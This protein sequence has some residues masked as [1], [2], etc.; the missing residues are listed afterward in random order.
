MVTGSRI[1]KVL[2]LALALTWAARGLGESLP[3]QLPLWEGNDIHDYADLAACDNGAGETKYLPPGISPTSRDSHE[4]PREWNGQ[5]IAWDE[6]AGYWVF[7]PPPG[8]PSRSGRCS[9]PAYPSRKACEANGFTWFPGFPE[10]ETTVNLAADVYGRDIKCDRT[11]MVNPN[12][13]PGQRVWQ[14]EV[15]GILWTAI[16]RRRAATR[17]RG[18]VA[19]MT[20]TTSG[21]PQWND[22]HESV[23]YNIDVGG[24]N[25]STRAATWLDTNQSGGSGPGKDPVTG[26]R[27][28]RYAVS[29]VA[30]PNYRVP[31]NVGTMPRAGGLRPW[32]RNEGVHA[33][34]WWDTVPLMN[35][36]ACTNCHGSV[37][38]GTEA[39]ARSGVRLGTFDDHTYWHAGNDKLGFPTTR[40]FDGARHKDTGDDTTSCT[41]CHASFMQSRAPGMRSLLD[42]M[43]GVFENDDWASDWRKQTTEPDARLKDPRRSHAMP[44]GADRT[45][46]GKAS[47]TKGNTT[48]IGYNWI[49]CMDIGGNWSIDPG[50]GHQ[51][52]E[53]WLDG[54]ERAKELIACCQKPFS[55][56]CSRVECENL[57]AASVPRFFIPQD[58]AE[59]EAAGGVFPPDNLQPGEYQYVRP[60]DPVVGPRLKAIACPKPPPAGTKPGDLCYSLEW[61]DSNGSPFNAAREFYWNNPT[62]K[63]GGIRPV[64]APDWSAKELKAME[65][66]PGTPG[67]IV[68]RTTERQLLDRPVGDRWRFA[69]TSVGP[70]ERCTKMAVWF[71]GGHCGSSK[72]EGR[73]AKERGTLLRLRHPA[74]DCDATPTP[75]PP[76]P[77][78]PASPTPTWTPTMTPTMTSAPRLTP[79]ASPRPTITV[80]PTRLSTPFPTPGPTRL[81]T[82]GP[83]R[84]ATPSPIPTLVVRATPTLSLPLPTET[85]TAT[86]TAIALPT[87]TAV[88]LDRL[89]ASD[90]ASRSR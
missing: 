70:L 10:D 36:D 53:T 17:F 84:S 67:N 57:R 87:A 2:S 73:P 77:T 49:E 90:R 44:K 12:C 14:K 65:Y 86:P 59:I 85:P 1:T 19:G 22:Q 89:R 63:N 32:T 34:L 35:R 42:W 78:P 15:D 21:S 60:P 23:F 79:T 13:V 26:A 64:H 18:P 31:G 81:P 38:N 33:S 9:D 40:F 54:Y 4:M 20:S 62:R 75:T 51:E 11:D 27:T 69:Y 25:L 30:D 52:S 61:E 48:Y 7:G 58:K 83:T 28:N 56:G 88:A 66:C 6:T 16:F 41:S 80:G 55:A 68:P 50:P 43:T 8:R 29:F 72:T 82:P 76:P 3:G 37:F 46:T 45:I 47:C 39:I 5:A 24:Y 74:T 71:C